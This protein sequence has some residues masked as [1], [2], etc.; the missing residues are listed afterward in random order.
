VEGSSSLPLKVPRS[1]PIDLKRFL[2]L[3]RY[4]D[5]SFSDLLS[6]ENLLIPLLANLS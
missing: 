5:E 3:S 4:L 6:R 1:A 2:A